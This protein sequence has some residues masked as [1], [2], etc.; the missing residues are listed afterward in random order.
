MSARSRSKAPVLRTWAGLVSAVAVVTALAVG[1]PAAS[2][3][4]GDGFGIA[5]IN[6][7]DVEAA[8][9]IP[10]TSAFWAGSCDVAAAPAFGEPLGTLGGFGSRPSSITVPNSS[11]FQ[12][13]QASAPAPGTPMGCIDY[14]A[15][16]PYPGSFGLPDGVIDG[17]VWSEPPSWRLPPQTQA[18]GHPDGSLTMALARGSNHSVDGT[19]DN[20]SVDLPAGF[21][22]NP[23]AA[24]Q[25]SGEQFAAWP[26]DCPASSQ[27]GVLSLHIVAAGGTGSYGGSDS[28]VYPVYNLEP[29]DGNVAEL[30]FGYASGERVVTVRVVARARTNG[31]FGVTTFIGQVP[32]ALPLIN[33]SITLWGVPWAASNDKWRAPDSY[34]RGS[35]CSAQPGTSIPA[36]QFYI[37]PSGFSPECQAHYVPEWG[38]IKPFVTNLTECAGIQVDVGMAID[39]YQDPGARTSDGDP[40]LSD[41]TNLEGWKY[42]SASSPPME[43][44]EKLPFDPGASFTPTS[45]NADSASGL[46]VDITVPQ[47]NDPPPD[48]AT[49]PSDVN[50][51]PAHW[52]S[53]AGLATSHLDSTVVTLPEGMSINPS[54]SA[55]LEGCSDAQI[56]LREI[57]N[58]NLFNNVEPTCPDG[59]KIGT[60]T[61]TT[62][63]LEEPLT[64]EVILG[65]P[66]SE[67]IDC[68]SSA[69]RQPSCP[70]TT[71]VFL[72]LRNEERGLLVK[73]YGSSISD[74]LTGRITATFDNN[75]RVPVENIQLSLKGGERGLFGMPQDCGGRSTVAEFSPWTAAHGAG[76]VAK[77]VTSAFDVDG[78]CQLGFTP[79]LQAGMSTKQAK[80]GGVFS[81]TFSRTDGQ[82][83]FRGLT[84]ELPTGLLAAVKSVPLC[85]NAQAN[86]NQ[87][88]AESRIGSVDAGAGSGLPF[89]LE[90]KGTAYL[91]E[92]YKGAPYGLA[93]SVPVEAGP[94]RGE[95]AL[96]P[97]VVRQ[98]LHVDRSDASVTAISDPFPEIWHGIPLRVRQVTVAVD[99][100]GFM[101]NP[102]NCDEKR[103]E[104]RLTS[105]RDAVAT[106]SV[107]FQA[108]GCSKLAFKPRLAM[109]LTGKRQMRTGTHP[110]VRAVVSQTAREAGIDRAVVR[111]P[112]SLALDPN[113]AQALCEFV[114]GT[115]PDLE[116]HCPKGSIVGRA[117]AVSPLLKRPLAGNVYFVKN[118]KRSSTGNLIRTLPMLIVALRGEIAINLKGES[119]TTH[120]GRLVNTFA[121][122]PDAPIEKFNLDIHGGK[123]GI[124]AV[125]RTKRARINLCNGKQIAEADMDG[126]NGRRHDFDVRMKTPC[127]QAKKNKKAKKK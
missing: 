23:T 11:Q 67:D 119:S 4:F 97:I 17:D 79:G 73:I 91:T 90:K 127:K 66:K 96:S 65:Q 99:R 62:P 76:G 80:A 3:A 16:D 19:L 81:F 123:N 118:V 49:N 77:T 106:P 70:L 86:A 21:V 78:A 108:D 40:D 125:T 75:P 89:F 14:G 1:A 56:G 85:T 34:V 104:A 84:A 110:G 43:G 113:N 28:V 105:T 8:P 111:L 82:Q 94:F 15:E 9:A 88:P 48:V 103:I 36:V 100:P 54:A 29:R 71:R 61:A 92:G 69:V 64:G 6:Q 38:P 55:G 112:P 95:L 68:G 35:D 22:G 33:Q 41:L 45:T 46:D 124:L 51:A 24:A 10:G 60:V 42:V 57:G 13:G 47:S 52:K 37:P 26:L 53:D 30:G 117:R 31:D 32:A 87:C 116:S 121:S 59:S 2:A 72:V 20:I 98:A 120:A 12:W 58:P 25:C 83:W 39:S 109:R 27:V 114:D 63:L 102:S 122:V 101:V 107:R 74:P 7:P 5:P 50:G 115:K 93:V 126:Q 44:C 18:G